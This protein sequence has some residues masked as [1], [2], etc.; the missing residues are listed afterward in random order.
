M[1]RRQR[2]MCIRDSGRSGQSAVI[3]TDVNKT[4]FI[5][6]TNGYITKPLNPVFHAYNGPS[7][8]N[9]NNDIVF[10][11]ERFDIGSAYNTSNGIYTVP[12]TGY[13][14]FHA[15]VYRQ[16]SSADSYWGFFINGTQRSEA[17]L[18]TDVTTSSAGYSTMPSSLYWYCSSGDEVKCR[19]ISGSIHCNT[20]FSYF[21]GNL[22]G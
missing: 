1:A 15:V 20:N 21:S 2:Q 10:S 11:L 4:G 19:C 9:A 7:N 16:N 3:I 18:K 17:R 5:Q 12:K 13:Y 14:H 8:V 22:I 6:D